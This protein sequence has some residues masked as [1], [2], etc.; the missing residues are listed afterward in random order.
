MQLPKIPRAPRA[1]G[2]LRLSAAW[3]AAQNFPLAETCEREPQDPATVFSST[4]QPSVRILLGASRLPCVLPPPLMGSD[5]L[6]RGIV[7]VSFPLSQ[8]FNQEWMV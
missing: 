4:S 2:Q 7:S 5:P 6:Q 3:N 8:P 1:A